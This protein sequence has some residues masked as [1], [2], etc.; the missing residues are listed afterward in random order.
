[1]NVFVPSNA[2]GSTRRD[3]QEINEQPILSLN[4][5]KNQTELEELPNYI[6]ITQALSYILTGSYSGNTTLDDSF[7][8][9]TLD[10]L[11]DLGLSFAVSVLADEIY[12]EPEKYNG[13][14]N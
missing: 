9:N 4:T 3:G 1:L 10:S 11:L 14:L 2:L 8:N 12:Y 13:Q 6:Y 7:D 5:Y